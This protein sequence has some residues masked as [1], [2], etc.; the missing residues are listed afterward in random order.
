MKKKLLHDISASSLQVIINQCCGFVIFYILSAQLTKNDFGE[1]NWTLAILLTTFGILSF[2]IDQIAIKK[3][4][5]GKNI[6]STLSVYIT[7]VLLSG[8]L[9]YALLFSGKFF[10]SNFYHNH[11]LLL[12]IAVGK[13]MVF[14]STPFKQLA[15]GLEKFRALLW[16]SVGSNILR[17][18]A[19]LVYAATQQLTLNSIIIIFITGDAI[20]LVICLLITRYRLKIPLLLQWNRQHYSQLI[21]ESLPQLGVAIFTSAIARIDWIFLGLLSSNI[22][23]ANYSFAYKIFEVATLPLLI[24]APILIPRFTRLFQ[25]S[26]VAEKNSEQLFTLL[27]AEIIIAS[28]AS[29]VLNI[30]WV[31]VIDIISNNK[32]GTVNSVNIL[33]LSA[34]MPFIYFNNFL[35]TINFAKGQLKLIFYIFLTC[36]IVNAVAT[37]LLIPAWGGEGAAT[38][39]LLSIILQSVLFLRRSGMA[40]SAAKI[41]SLLLPPLFAAAAG[42]LMTYTFTPSWLI[43]SS[44]VIIYLTALLFT[45]QIR[46][47]HWHLLRQIS[48]L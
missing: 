20:E 40:W 19:L 28:L 24:I 22:V 47:A 8:G 15:T 43:L 31:P 13:L 7:H 44:A 18:A 1:I 14:F 3:I 48:G 21:K 33:I 38:A 17:S 2:G 35:W 36:F 11:Q 45:K 32:Y 6:Q 34:S 4:A 16:M 42:V 12:L 5:E 9:V 46:R 29:L 10:F 23:L 25:K 37:V 30:L 41:L 26:P 27:R 39:Y